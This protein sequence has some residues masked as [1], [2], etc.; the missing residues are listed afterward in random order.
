[1]VVELFNVNWKVAWGMLIANYFFLTGLSA[2]SFLL[3]ALSEVFGQEKYRSVS[4]M[5][6]ILATILLIIAPL[7][8]IAELG[9]TGRFWTL[10]TGFHPT[11][12][13]AW[14]SFLLIAY[15]LLC[16][17][18][19]YFL[20]RRDNAKRAVSGS[21]AFLY[22]ALVLWRTDL[23]EA[24][25]AFDKKMVKTLAIIGIPLAFAVH[26]YTGYILGVVVAR[27]LWST[28]QMPVLFLLSAMV[29]GTAL[30]ILI[31]YIMQK[32]FSSKKYAD[33]TLIVNL[34]TL[35]MVF[36][37]VDMLY[38]FFELTMRWY[39]YELSKDSVRELL[40][41]KVS[42]YF[43]WIE[44]IL[45]AIIPFLLVTIPKIRKNVGAVLLASALSLMG[46]FAMR[47]DFVVGGQFYSRNGVIDNLYT[48]FPLYLPPL[49]EVMPFAAIW[50]LGFFMFALAVWTLPWEYK[51]GAAGGD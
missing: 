25:I 50:A 17:A 10:L 29:S 31:V 51:E 33:S 35:L 26:G 1:M 24:T 37:L 7:N 32:F 20:F 16:V 41:G 18:E 49:T 48:S 6:I 22:R 36:L 14:G 38:I 9:Q 43:V 19:G 5:A 34:G 45:G 46:V 11:S 15:P 47:M 13:M 2:G 8:L 4:K 28:P 27:N 23:T 21:M 42:F 44:M 39:S 12:P 30:M 3:G 40:F